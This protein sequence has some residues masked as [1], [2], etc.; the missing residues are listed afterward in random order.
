MKNLFLLIAL[1]MINAFALKAENK[2]IALNTNN[3]SLIYSIDKSGKLSFQYYGK[4]IK[5]VT[6]FG[7]IK[8]YTLNGRRDLGNEAYPTNEKSGLSR[9]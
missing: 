9:Q 2:I 5:D 4:L 8:L 3:T 6:P 1:M 7:G